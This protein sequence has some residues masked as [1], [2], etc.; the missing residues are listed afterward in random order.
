MLKTR[1]APHIRFS[2]LFLVLAA[3]FGLLY[4]LQLLG[5]GTDLIRPDLAR[6]LHISLMLYG[7]IPLM[8]TLLPFALFDR[9]GVMDEKAAA[10]L[11]RFLW[12]WYTFLV[13]MI[14]SL[15]SGVRRG[16]PFYD[17]P[18][19]LN[20]LL[21]LAGLFYIAAIFKS[22]ANYERKPLWVKVS[23]VLV[24]VSPFALLVLMNP[25]YGQVEK[26]LMG[27][28][29]D[30][31][32][33][34][35]FALVAVYYLA[36]K[37]A[38]PKRT[39]RTRWHILWIIPLVCY[40]GSVLYR[41]FVGSLSYDAEWF[42]QYLTL[43]YIPLLALW[44]KDAGLSLKKHLTLFISMAAFLFADVEGNIL[45]IPHLRELFHRN[46]LVVGHAHVAV[47]IGLLFLALSIVEPF[48]R[49]S[50]KRALYLTAMLLLMALVL[51]VSGFAQ[52]GFLP[53]Q[54]EAMWAL[55]AL[56]GLLFIG[57]L[58]YGPKLA[59][60]AF[61]RRLRWVDGYNLAGFLSDGLGGLMLVLF[62]GSL[63]HFL[64]QGYAPGYQQI[65][66]G[67]VMGVGLIHLLGMLMPAYAYAMAEAT[68]MVRILTAAGFF[69]LYKAGVLGW[70]ALA[71]ALVDLAF[72]L[73]YLLGVKERAKRL[74]AEAA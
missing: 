19:E 63:Y 36:V 57:G 20:F 65:V 33:G 49:I 61:I 27:P 28:H 64:G 45:F 74:E 31:T 12:V 73:A 16:L 37:L 71:V 47:G 26:M 4:A 23:L 56:F 9:D 5:I 62:G 54:I 13:F 21:A 29:G 1:L 14:F 41:S 32:L 25:K 67:F 43:L 53:M 10:Y 8:M 7:F 60:P 70:I 52:A 44:W 58:L 39:F 15:L 34:M 3:F 35:S 72:V 30:N 38:S 6:S 69:A 24:V 51:T 55:R 42:L 40:L 50:A 48:V 11:E 66:F 18:Y 46:D 68:V 17:F 22:I 59:F 2:Y